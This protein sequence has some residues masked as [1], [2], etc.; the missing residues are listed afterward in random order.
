[1]NKEAVINKKEGSK[2]RTILIFFVLVLLVSS[3][4]YGEQQYNPHSGKWE[5]VP[6]GSNWSTQYNPHD[7]TWSYQPKDAQTEYNPHEGKWE[8]DSGHNPGRGGE[9]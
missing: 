2:M 4:G 9:E 6:D 3:T 5:T 8:W 7:G 1:M